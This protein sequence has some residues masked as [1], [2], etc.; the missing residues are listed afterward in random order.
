M[1]INYEIAHN[2]ITGDIMWNI[3]DT[4]L[5]ITDCGYKIVEKFIETNKYEDYSLSIYD[6][7]TTK[8]IEIEANIKE[9][10]EI[11]SN[12]YAIEHATPLYFIGVNSLTNSYVVGMNLTKGNMEFGYYKYIDGKLSKID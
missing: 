3:D 12:I 10:P 6:K 7:L 2:P 11:V 4:N 8:T 1:E 5:A 9:F